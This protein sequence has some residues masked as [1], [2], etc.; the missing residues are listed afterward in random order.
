MAKKKPSPRN[1]RRI[2]YMYPC[3]DS[4]FLLDSH[5]RSTKLVSWR[6]IFLGSKKVSQFYFDNF[7]FDNQ[8]YFL[9]RFDKIRQYVRYGIDGIGSRQI[10][11]VN[12]SFEIIVRN[13]LNMD[14]IS[15]AKMFISSVCIIQF[16]FFLW[17]Y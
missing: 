4:F 8:E 13:R 2:L 17:S 1:A 16:I 9:V 14:V 12:I 15:F 6:R 11:F 3:G 10:Y 5:F 7:I